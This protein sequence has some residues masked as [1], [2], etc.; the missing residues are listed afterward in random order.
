LLVWIPVISAV[1]STLGAISAVILAWRSDSRSAKETV[2]KIAQL[3]QELAA[4][5]GEPTGPTPS[6]PKKSRKKLR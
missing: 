1:T 5:K 6:L 3:E 2:L 4:A